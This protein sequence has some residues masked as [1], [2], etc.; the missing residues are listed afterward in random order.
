MVLCPSVG[1]SPDASPGASSGAA[2]WC[3]FGL[4]V[5]RRGR[6]VGS[7]GSAGR[8]GSAV[9]VGLFGGV[10]AA[11]LEPVA[12]AGSLGGAAAVGARAVRVG[13]A[14]ATVGAAAAPVGVGEVAA[15]GGGDARSADGVGWAVRLGLTLW[16][17]EALA[18]FV[19]W[20]L[21]HARA[22]PVAAATQ[23]ARATTGRTRRLRNGFLGLACVPR[24]SGGCSSVFAFGPS[25]GPAPADSQPTDPKPTGAA[26]ASPGSGDAGSGDAGSAGPD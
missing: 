26:S 18:P 24:T 7:A 25:A 17:T 19:W 10:A 12:G 13:V 15:W 8:V 5:G 1:A 3:G 21:G 9:G 11:E 4:V 6:V 22:V 20:E 14:D 23:A 2:V 16:R